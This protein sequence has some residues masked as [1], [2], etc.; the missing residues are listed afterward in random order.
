MSYIVLARK[1]RPQN[2]SEVYAQDHV[3][4]ILQSAIASGRIAHA[5]LFTGPRGVGKTSL[6][7]I[8]AKSL[9]C[10]EGPTT[11][12]CN[13]CTN[14]MEITAG[15]SPDV[16]EI[17]GASNTGVDDI[18][19]LQRELLYAASGAKYKI[20]I[21]D[22]V[23][24]L[25][26]SAFNALLKT[27]EEP[28]ENVIFIFATTE[29]HKV[30][31]TIISR[32]QRYDFKRI[33]VDAIVQRL[34]DLAI[35]EGIRV[36]DESLYL[37]ARKADGGMRDALS[38]MDQ[39]I[40]Y[41][42][43][44]ITID[45]VRQIFGMIPNQVYHDFMLLIHAHDPGSLIEML[46]QIFEEGTDLQEFIANMLEYLRI[47]ILSKLGIAIKD[48]SQDE[49]PLFEEIASIFSQTD[50]LYVM[51]Q[52]MQTR[53]DIRLSGNPY[54]LIE[55]TMIKLARLE[56]ISDIAQL[57]KDLQK[58]GVS[59]LPASSSSEKPLPTVKKPEAAPIRQEPRSPEPELGK[60]EFNEE[61]LEQNWSKLVTRLKKGSFVSGI[62]MEGAKKLGISGNA[63]NLQ[64]D[65]STRLNSV[66]TN[67]ERI[68]AMFTDVFGKPIHLNCLLEEKEAPTRVEIK[69]KTID[70]IKAD[71]PEIASFIE[72]T[73]ARL[74]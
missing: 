20:Y 10:L 33:P 71:N 59:P 31:P 23:H 22:E 62:A 43:N 19:E 7:R 27:L 2:F 65:S 66:K 30:L 70:D 44:D 53:A 26:K 68:E 15:V 17:D 28:P 74:L 6:A 63:I 24:M 4:R 11:T 61:V 45:R 48:V 55:A 8:M 25:S 69:R 37:I 18:R 34:K 1:Y 49:L 46:H 29:P 21:I 32:C 52:L 40:S 39:T 73:N 12:P 35:Q 60:L 3:T 56:E 5:Y 57:I 14:C 51:S 47:V 64:F 38:L 72:Q 36:D 58:G 16:I 67:L 9:N 54:L 50:L 41:C 13:K 42:M